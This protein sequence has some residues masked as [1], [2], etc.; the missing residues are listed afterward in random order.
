MN[1]FTD[2]EFQPRTYGNID[3]IKDFILGPIMPFIGESASV[4]QLHDESISQN[5]LSQAN[6]AST[7][8]YDEADFEAATTIINSLQFV[9]NDIEQGLECK[10]DGYYNFSSP[11]YRVSQTSETQ[12]ELSSRQSSPGEST[13]LTTEAARTLDTETEELYRKEKRRE[14]NRTAQ[15]AYRRRRKRVVHE[16]GCEIQRLKTELDLSLKRNAEL[17]QLVATFTSRLDR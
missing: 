6:P 12:S 7:L 9:G 14:Q 8:G 2:Y 15:Q 11:I 10:A 3:I 4:A 16:A 17:S 5:T 13:R 1:T